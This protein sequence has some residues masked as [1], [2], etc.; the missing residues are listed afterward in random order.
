[1]EKQ[2]VKIYETVDVIQAEMINNHLKAE[3][4]DCVMMNKRSSI[5]PFGN[6]EIWVIEE[7][8]TESLNLIN[9]EFENKYPD[10]QN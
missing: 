10:N 1:M 6:V 3:S 8:K 9:N 2:W 5:L 4:I 7:H